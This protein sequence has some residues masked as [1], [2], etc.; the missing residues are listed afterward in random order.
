MAV[1]PMLGELELELVQ[2]IEA[3]EE[4]I[5]VQHAVPTLEGDFLQ[6]LGRRAARVT[7]TGVLA[8][9][10]V[11]ERLKELRQKFRAAE[12]VPFVADIATAV[13]LQQVLIEEMGVRE[14]AG[15]PERFEYAFTLREFI[16]PPEPRVEPPPPPPPP[17]PTTAA[18]LIV[19]V[20]VEGRPD[21]DFSQVQVRVDGEQRDG[22]RLDRPLTNQ[23]GNRWTEEDFPPGEYTAH[24]SA[25]DPSGPM[26]N[27]EPAVVRSGQE[28][29]VRIVLRPGQQRAVAYSYI[30]HFRFDKAFVEPCMRLVLRQVAE[31]V[32]NRDEKLLI[33]GH[34]DKSGGDTYNLS[35]GDRRARAVYAYLTYGNDSGAAVA[36]WNELRKGSTGTLPSTRDKWGVRQYQYMLQDLGYLPGNVDGDHGSMTNQAVQDFRADK[37]LPPGNQVDDTVW[38][39]LIDAYMAQ[40]SLQL[41]DSKLLRNAADGCDGGLLRWLSCGEQIPRPDTPTASCA[42]EIAWRPNRRVELLITSEEELPCEVPE[43][44]TF[45]LPSGNP[46]GDTWCLGPGNPDQRCCFLTRDESQEDKWLVQEA[47]PDRLKVSGSI[48]WADGTPLGN[49]HYVLIAPD[50]TFMDGEK[51]CGDGRGEG[52]P[53][54]TQPDGTFD[55]STGEATIQGVYTMEVKLPNGPHVAYV[56]GEPPSS[57]KGSVVCKRLSL[58]DSQFH[59]II[60]GIAATFDL[61]VSG[62][63]RVGGSS[64]NNYM[65]VRRQDDEVIVTAVP[66]ENAA[67]SPQGIQW[68]GGEE[69]PGQPLQR[70][71]SIDTTG[72]ITVTATMTANGTTRSVEIFVVQVTLDVDADRDGSVEEDAEGKDSWEFGAGAKGAVILCNNDDDNRSAGVDNQ[73]RD[74]D[75]DDDVQ[76]LAPLVIRQSGVVPAGASLSLEIVTHRDKIRVF[77]PRSSSG[78]A[79]LGPAPLPE[80]FTVTNSET[81]DVELGMEAT[82]YPDASFDGLIRLALVLK[83]STTEV[84]RDEVLVRVAPWMMPSHMDETTE[85]YV[86]RTT[87]NTVAHPP[88]TTIFLDEITSIAAS[89]G[90]PLVI[91]DGSTYGPDPCVPSNSY[92]DRWVQDTME[93][94]Y[95]QMPGKSNNVVLRA[96][97]CRPLQPLALN[98]L[99]GPDYGYVE[100][101]SPTGDNTFDAHGNIEVSP[102]VQ[103][104][105]K[106]YKFGRIFYGRGRP[107]TPFNHEVEQFLISQKVQSPFKIDTDWLAVGHVDEIISFIPDQGGKGFKMLFPDTGEAR[108]ILGDLETAGHGDLP[109][110]PGQPEEITI[111]D[112][113]T[114]LSLGTPG[115]LGWANDYCQARLDGVKNVM[116]T[117]LDLEDTDIVLF[118]SLFIENDRSPRRLNPVRQPVFDA[119]IPGMVNLLLIRKPSLADT[120]LVIADPFGPVLAGVDQ[121]KQAVLD[122]LTLLGYSAGQ[123]HFVDDYHT[124][125]LQEGEVHCGTNSRRT[126]PTTA[127]WE[128]TDF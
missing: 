78:I 94:G 119:F 41:N 84:V 103:A 45:R 124:Y 81:A 79:I 121:F 102:P 24:A 115:D 80:R 10:S 96:H 47:E 128:Q 12:P 21:F 75:G 9:E 35:L 83:E 68:T 114:E 93:V 59:V 64:S 117:E 66:P 108:R 46:V 51:L 127:W 13:R 39:T 17:P 97:R 56:E 48:C 15:K 118:P 19:E 60:S 106:D 85:L 110:F 58:D 38:E 77:D 8:G 44:V 120:H 18:R 22:P 72:Q 70:H 76:D 116:K 26:R 90:V 65:A 5:R 86:I 27:S 91:G 57:G 20:I 61:Q 32:A 11:G 111:S 16:P 98:E 99:L 100:I 29:F 4:Q 30:V 50:G 23:A 88:G 69:V 40:D 67:I 37:G 123:I 101:S 105:G 109:V 63:T 43:P 36:E 49:N 122:K 74:I 112:L 3:D 62:A 113:L 107:T 2:E 55:Y 33:V 25:E 54:R 82:Q 1:K 31:H 92:E 7:L 14:L 6:P 104:N 52:N 34:T 71:V 73:N 87:D 53:G 42:P 89:L 95:S 125:H 126:P 28:T